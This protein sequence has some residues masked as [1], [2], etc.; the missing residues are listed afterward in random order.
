MA[1]RDGDEPPSIEEYVDAMVDA[2]HE[3]SGPASGS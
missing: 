1:Y 2:V 3:T